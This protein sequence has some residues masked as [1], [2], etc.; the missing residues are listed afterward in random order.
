ME[1]GSERGSGG[2]A[3]SVTVLDRKLSHAVIRIPC[4]YFILY[5][6]ILLSTIS[7]NFYCRIS[8]S[9]H[10]FRTIF[11]SSCLA[12]HCPGDL[13]YEMLVEA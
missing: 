5:I 7:V 12:R 2:L 1:R 4:F 6:Y 11:R 9:A 8:H 3:E 10:G 13:T